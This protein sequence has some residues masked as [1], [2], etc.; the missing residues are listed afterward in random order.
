MSSLKH[1]PGDFAPLLLGNPSA[2][3]ANRV[4]PLIAGAESSISWIGSHP[5]CSERQ[6]GAGT[7]E[8]AL[9]SPEAE[10]KRRKKKE[11]R[12]EKI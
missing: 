11:K 12:K 2:Q 1:V 10:K 4:Q 6:V 7:G 8:T 3:L 9:S 5:N